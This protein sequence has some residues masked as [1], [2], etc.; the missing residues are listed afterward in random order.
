M[1]IENL[2]KIFRP[3]S[4]AIVGASERKKSIGSI[5]MRNLIEGGFPGE[6]YPINPNHKTLWQRPAC[7]SIKDLRNPIDLAVISMPIAAAVHAIKDCA[8]AGAGG[9]VI[10]SAGGKEVGEKGKNVEAAIMQEAS[11]TGLRVIGPNCAGIMSSRAK[12]NASFTNRMPLPGK[13]AFVSQSG[14]LCTAI[15]DLSVTENIGFSHFVSLGDMLD[16]DFGDMIDYLGGEPEVSSIVMYVEGLTRF[17]KFMSAARAVS[18]VKPIVALKAGKSQAGALAA[19]SHTGAL[20]GEDAVYDSAF[21]RAGILRVKTFE[22]LFDCAELLA[23]QPKPAGHGLVIISNA[24]GPAV[25]AADALSDHGC[26]P[27]ALSA[28]TVEKLDEIMS[29]DWSRRNPIE[30]LGEA[31]PE[32]YRKV[33]EI[34]LQTKEVN[35]ILIM[36]A[37]QAAIDPTKVAK[38]LIDT[39]R[40][41][42]I[43]IITSW[44]GGPRMQKGRAVFNQAGIPT[45]D[46][47]ERAVRAFMDIYRYSKNIEMLQ[48]IPSR[49]PGRL[50]FDRQRA[51]TLIQAGL[52]ARNSLLTELE[53]K[54][55]L[56][57][58]GIPVN[59]AAM[60]SSR[61]E[62]GKAAADMGFPVV[63]KI[64]SRDIT[65]KSTAKGVVL[66]L[67]NESEV[68]E[69]YDRIVQDAR[70]IYPDARIEGVTVQPMHPRP[71]FE[72]LLGTKMDRDFGPVILFGMGGILTEVIQDRAIALPPLNRLLARRL[73]E[74]TRVYR[75]LQGYRNVPAADLAMLEEILIRLAQLV[76]DFAEIEELDINPLFVSGN[77]ACVIDARVVLRPS[78]TRSPLHL[79]I[80]PYP[81]QYEQHVRTGANIDIFIRPIRPEDAPLLIELFESLSPRSVYMRFFTPLKRLSNSM[82]ARFTQIDYDREI[83]LV[84][85]AEGQTAER[86]LGVARIITQNNQKKAEFS[87]A[88]G[89]AWQGKGIGAE[90]LRRCLAIAEKRGIE[91]VWGTILAENIQMLALAKK[92]G[93]RFKNSPGTGEYELSIDLREKKPLA[94]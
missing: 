92:L 30:M 56:S 89:D 43:P 11:R 2:D 75:S 36:A 40:G 5:L 88:V 70:A 66:N 24:G 18:T 84:A 91:E 80:S 67:Q 9:V 47:P 71:D 60:A 58:Y 48:Q 37:P 53:A 64:N 45:F 22:E 27:V 16:V 76:T 61:E 79:V 28:E 62:A 1:G 12:L 6:I 31:T 86:M 54:A 38:S 59:R 49:L 55:L 73:M 50:D 94:F 72:L 13:M 42:P 65:H 34:C 68:V 21:Q 74:Q 14:A 39:I 93:F 77:D 85:L 26:E 25:M 23:K 41:K 87:V 82:L 8:E 10:I 7:P 33:I 81:D 90:L 20:A 57:A 35:G 69:A 46:T 4:I 51:K 78:Q 19:V 15:L 63:L 32:L 3:K 44:V 29:P 17:R 52:T 83:A